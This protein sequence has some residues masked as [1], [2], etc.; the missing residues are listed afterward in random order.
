MA[1]IK[2]KREPK[3]QFGQFFTPAHIAQQLL[4]PRALTPR[5]RVLEPGFGGGAFLLPLIERFMRLRGD[6]LEAILNENLW[7]V[8][9]DESIYTQTL[10][11]I[12]RHFG[13][14]P[15]KHNLILG[16]YLD[17]QVLIEFECREGGLLSARNG[18]DL[19]IGNPPFGGTISLHLQDVLEKLHGRRNGFKI[20]RE[21]YSLFIVK[22]L[23]LLKPGGSLEFICSDTFLTI[24]TMRGLRNALMVEG[25]SEVR[26][27]PEF[28]EETN[29][30]MVVL[31]HVKGEAASEVRVDGAALPVERIRSTGNYSWRVSSDM[32]PM[33]EGPLLSEYIVASSGMTT[34]KNEYFV[35]ELNEAGG[36]E[37]PYEFTFF[38]EPVT[39]RRELERARLGRISPKKQAEIS[40]MEYSGATRRNV[41]I[42][43]RKTPVSLAMPHP[44]YR[45][46]NKAVAGR[47]Y[48]PP[49]HVIY[50]KDSGDAVKTFK[51][52][53]NWYLHGVGGAP[54]FEREGMTWRLISATIDMRY[55]PPGYILDSGAPCAFLRDGVAN[56]ELWFILGWANSSIA[57]T[58]MKSVL[59]HTMNIQSKDIERLPYPWWVGADDKL[60]AIRLVREVVENAQRGSP[61]DAHDLARICALYDF[62]KMSVTRVT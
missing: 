7:G 41:R 54:Y 48:M 15:K 11:D 31:H 52:N 49:R 40:A 38:Q 24:P 53:G 28:S 59:N 12:E 16:D 39:L 30:P 5:M 46:Y 37:E 47:F 10:Q 50:W 3:R 26:R 20:K 34:G 1:R 61:P 42:V 51:K 2:H 33:F 55:L 44:D 13:R 36:F 58:L 14:L 25:R 29:Y 45:Y 6:D 56:D 43:P 23:D 27:L 17:P 32:S 57:T 21:S 4:L 62:E 9:I 18:F 35:R 19:V 8:E 22:S 60:T